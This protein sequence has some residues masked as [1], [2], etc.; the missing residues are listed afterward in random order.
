[1]GTNF[2]I[3]IYMATRDTIF[4]HEVCHIGR[5][6]HIDFI[7]LYD[8]FQSFVKDDVLS[9]RLYEFNKKLRKDKLTEAD[10]IGFRELL[11]TMYETYTSTD[12]HCYNEYDEEMSFRAIM[13]WMS[14][15]KLGFEK[16]GES[17]YEVD[18]LYV[19]LNTGFI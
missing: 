1:M 9:K 13:E 8:F 5:S 11:C 16:C 14:D 18:G 7:S 6:R 2:Y 19:D 17:S 12:F 4:I 3:R 15:G 10:A